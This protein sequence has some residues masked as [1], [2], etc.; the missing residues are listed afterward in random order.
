MNKILIL[1]GCSRGLG[2]E[3]KDKYLSEGYKVIGIDAIKAKNSPN[4]TFIERN[5]IDISKDK[6]MLKELIK[7]IRKEIPSQCK[8]IVLINNAALQVIKPIDKIT[9]KEL[10]VQQG[11][12]EQFMCI[13]FVTWFFITGLVALRVSG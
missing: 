6:K 3:L 13:M 4:F 1:T 8:K 9:F 10:E 12:D 7:F 11:R 2:L 5:L